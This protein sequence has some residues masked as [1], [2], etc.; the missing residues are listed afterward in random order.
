[1]TDG[2]DRLIGGKGA[3]RLDG[4][5]GDDRLAGGA[6]ADTFR[7]GPRHGRDTITDFTP[8]TDHLRL[9]LPGQDFGDLALRAAGGDTVI[10]TGAGRILLENISPAD[11][12]PDDVLFG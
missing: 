6:G 5:R 3:D 7:F 4:G 9:T 8:G 1:M 12:G 11:L 10:R 2:D